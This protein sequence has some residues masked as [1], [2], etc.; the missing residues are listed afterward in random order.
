VCFVCEMRCRIKKGSAQINRCWRR[1][2]RQADA[3]E[4]QGEECHVEL[5]I[6]ALSAHTRR[7]RCQKL[8]FHF[9]QKVVC[10]LVVLVGTQR[11]NRGFSSHARGAWG[12]RL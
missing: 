1:E 9:E 4:V 6:K 2:M 10:A 8:H 5:V 7:F 12:L 3:I 11:A